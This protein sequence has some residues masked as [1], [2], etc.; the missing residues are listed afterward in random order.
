MIHN[1]II[2]GCTATH[3][4]LLSLPLYYPSSIMMVNV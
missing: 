2:T 1:T 4:A 3:N